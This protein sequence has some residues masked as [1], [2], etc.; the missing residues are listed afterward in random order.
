[1]FDLWSDVKIPFA[2]LCTDHWYKRYLIYSYCKGL[3]Y[4]ATLLQPPTPGKIWAIL[5][6]LALRVRGIVIWILGWPSGWG[7][8]ESSCR[9]LLHI[10]VFFGE[11]TVL[12]MSKCGHNNSTNSM[13]S[14]DFG[15]VSSPKGFVHTFVG[16]KRT[17]T[18]I[19]NGHTSTK[20]V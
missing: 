9:S 5:T 19:S 14:S 2:I 8:R 18:S 7:C 20:R 3:D 17:W 6:V 16:L 10:A 11:G 13:V 15:I 12:L 4:P 1:M